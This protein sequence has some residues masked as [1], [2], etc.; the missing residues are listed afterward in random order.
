A[1]KFGFPPEEHVRVANPIAS[2]QSLM[3]LSLLPGVYHN[4]VENSKNFTSFRLFEIGR[5]IY[6]KATG[7]PEEVTHLM[8]AMYEKESDGAAGL[9]ELKRLADCL[10]PAS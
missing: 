5:E 4:L 7:L 6:K 8:A 3:R 10:M 9:F 2:D 1:T